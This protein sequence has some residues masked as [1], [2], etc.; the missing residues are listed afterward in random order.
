MNEWKI[1][2][3]ILE[4]F[5]TQADFAHAMGF[6]PVTLSKKLNGH[7]EWTRAEIEKACTLLHIAAEETHAYFFA[8]LSAFS[9]VNS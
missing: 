6:S 7:V 2:G 3:R 4:Y 1:K 9:H 8:N 5:D